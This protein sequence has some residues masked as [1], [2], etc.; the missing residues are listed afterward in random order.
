MKRRT[1]LQ[2]SACAGLAACSERLPWQNPPTQIL[3]PG[4]EMGHRLRDGLPSPNPARE[5]RCEVAILGSGAAGH[6]AAWRLAQQGFKDFR[7]IAGPEPFG[8]TAAAQ[9]GGLASPRGAHYLPLP[10]RDMGYIR[11]ML[12]ALNILQGDASALRPS[13]DE[14]VLVHAPEERLYVNG[15]WQEGM[16]P[17][18][19]LNASDKAQI[20]RFFA[21]IRD[22]RQMKGA[23]GRPAFVIPL[24]QSSQDPALRQLDQERFTDW[25]TRQGYTA[26]ALRWYLDYCCRDDYGSHAGMVS[27]WAGIHYFAS[28]GGH[29][30]NAEDGAVLTWQDGLHGLTQ[31][32]RHASGEARFTPGMAVRVRETRNGVEVLCL[33]GAAKESFLLKARR[34]IVAMPLHVAAHVLNLAEF[35]FDRA[36]DLPRSAS[37]MVSNFLLKGFPPESDPHRPLAWDNAVYGSDSLGWVV[38]T[39]QWIRLAK[40]EYTVF[41]AYHAFADQTPEETRRWMESAR[42]DELREIAERD[43]RRVYGKG[44]SRWVQQI[45]ICL[46]GHAM[47]SPAPGFLSRPGIDALRAADGRILFA[48][49]DLS[50]LSIF[51]EAAWWA[52][53]ASHKILSS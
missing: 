34:V 25:L 9:L 7:V 3:R 15:Q 19:G 52:E 17:Y 36:R 38:A 33:D 50:G 29:A 11:E 16:I 39:H 23:D 14:R 49:A 53:Q 37:W 44:F 43:L 35:G 4:M 13:Y 8:N 26:P 31:Q 47:A 30:A 32:L 40:P 45:E 12:A 20:T 18:L 41:T 2:L 10:T 48:H 28:R 6:F 21:Q 22:F 27:A 42:A 51:E 5:M 24:A 46:R 1:F